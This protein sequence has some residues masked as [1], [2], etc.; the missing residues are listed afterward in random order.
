MASSSMVSSPALSP[1]PTRRG[2]AGGMAGKGGGGGG[3]D[4]REGGGGGGL[5]GAVD[6]P[7]DGGAVVGDGEVVVAV[8]GDGARSG[9]P[10]LAVAFEPD[11]AVGLVPDEPAVGRV[12][13]ALAE[14]RGPG[15]GEGVELG[16]QLDGER[17]VEAQWC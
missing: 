13:R 14:E 3:C 6:V 2:S 17:A 16:E 9:A 12:G 10:L 5:G 11:G 15:V 4:G 7:A 8:G 1:W